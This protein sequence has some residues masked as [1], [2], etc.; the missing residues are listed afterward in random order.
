VVTVSAPAGDFA[1]IDPDRNGD[2]DLLVLTRN[3][4]QETS[5]D[6]LRLLTGDG[7]GRFS[8]IRKASTGTP[9]DRLVDIAG[10]ASSAGRRLACIGGDGVSLYSE[11]LEDLDKPRRIRTDSLDDPTA[12]GDFDGDGAIDLASARGDSSVSVF[13]QATSDRFRWLESHRLTGRLQDLVRADV[14][15]DGHQDLVA[16]LAGDSGSI[17]LLGDGTGRFV[18]GSGLPI[19]DFP[20]REYAAD[21]NGDGRDELIVQSDFNIVLFTRDPAGTWARG[22]EDSIGAEVRGLTAA[23]VNGDG[24]KDLLVVTRGGCGCDPGPRTVEVLL[25]QPGGR[26]ERS[27]GYGFPCEV[28]SVGALDVTRDGVLDLVAIGSDG[29]T[30]LPGLPRKQ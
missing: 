6:T 11:G 16:V 4:G 5:R 3:Y 15:G 20:T 28:Y 24:R 26:L 10:S 21:T 22:A 25:G 13:R 29:V 1:V 23:D 14:D 9:C 7:T 12:L 17:E 8:E 19:G 27:I 18:P 30:V 2:P